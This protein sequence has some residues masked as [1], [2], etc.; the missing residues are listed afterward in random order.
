MLKTKQRVEKT[1]F[2]FDDLDETD[3]DD[4]EPLNYFAEDRQFSEDGF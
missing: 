2:D 3:E 1:L 4:D